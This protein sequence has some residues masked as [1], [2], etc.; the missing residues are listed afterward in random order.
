MSHHLLFSLRMYPY[1]V[2]GWVPLFIKRT[3]HSGSIVKAALFKRYSRPLKTSESCATSN[4]WPT[5][6]LWLEILEIWSV[7]SLRSG[8]NDALNISMVDSPRGQFFQQVE[9]AS[10]AS[11][12]NNYLIM[13]ACAHLELEAHTLIS[14]SELSAVFFTCFSTRAKIWSI[15][16]SKH[17]CISWLIKLGHWS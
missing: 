15:T 2:I 12:Q 11:N 16:G 1:L 17:S 9:R 5:G 3:V 4:C 14:G 8:W 10:K 13:L 7:K 6:Y